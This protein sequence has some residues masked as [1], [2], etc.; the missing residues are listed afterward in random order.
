MLDASRHQADAFDPFDLDQEAPGLLVIELEATI[1]Q[2]WFD[3]CMRMY[4]KQSG[5]VIKASRTLATIPIAGTSARDK[6]LVYLFEQENEKP[7]ATDEERFFG[8]ARL[9]VDHA[10][11]KKLNGEYWNN[12]MWR[13]GVNAA[14]KITLT[15]KSDKVRL[16][17]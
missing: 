13:R 14:G 4:P 8:A 6:E 16:R 10:N 12:R 5:G 15:R 2:T 11:P 9:V 1:E 7:A 17:G 3:I